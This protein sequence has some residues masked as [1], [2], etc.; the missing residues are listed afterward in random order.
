MLPPSVASLPTTRRQ[1][2]EITLLPTADNARNHTQASPSRK[3]HFSIK[4]GLH[5]RSVGSSENSVLNFNGVSGM[6]SISENAS[7]RPKNVKNRFSIAEPFRLDQRRNYSYHV[8]PAHETKN[9]SLFFFAALFPLKT[10][11]RSISS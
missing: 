11:R 10:W 9:N 2:E 5:S 6:E 7:S 4:N 3:P 1:M 8:S